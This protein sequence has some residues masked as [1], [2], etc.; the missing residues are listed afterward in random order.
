V[1]P[2]AAGGGARKS[3][4]IDA[5]SAILLF[6]SRWLQSAAAAYTLKAAESV[7]R[8]LTV[9][10]YPGSDDFRRMV[11]EGLLEVLPT[12]AGPPL[13][14]DVAALDPGERE[15][16]ALFLAGRADFIIIDDGRGSAC[17]RRRGIPYVNA[18]L[19]P[20][21]LAPAAGAQAQDVAQAVQEIFRLGHYASWVLDFALQSSPEA[22]AV[23]RP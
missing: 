17:C 9:P 23:F 21:L 13:P 18:L 8:E 16:I 5:S 19:M 7:R 14:A 22:L 15:C 20:R 2:A 1:K 10:G 6:K 11:A 4:L 3:A 12:C